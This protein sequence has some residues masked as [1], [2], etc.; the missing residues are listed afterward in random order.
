VQE[1]ACAAYCAQRGWQVIEVYVDERSSAYRPGV[2]R[3]NFERL[4]GDVEAGVID[5]VVV[6]RLD[7]LTRSASDFY[8]N[9][10]NRLNTHGAEFVSVNEGFDTTTAMG[11]AMLTVAVAFA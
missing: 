4:M 3:R 7:R 5:T 2:R 1:K 8:E 9:I 11:R 6:Y 10:W